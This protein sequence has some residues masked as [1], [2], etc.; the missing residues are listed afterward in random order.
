MKT[1]TS[2]KREGTDDL[3]GNVSDDCGVALL[4][5]DVK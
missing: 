4:L 1:M 3:H 5:I 2:S